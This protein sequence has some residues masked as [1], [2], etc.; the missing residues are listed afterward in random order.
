MSYLL[1]QLEV[2]LVKLLLSCFIEPIVE[3]IGTS[4]GLCAPEMGSYVYISGVVYRL[5]AFS[6]WKPSAPGSWARVA[7]P[8]PLGRRERFSPRLNTPGKGVFA[9]YPLSLNTDAAAA[10]SRLG[11]S[12]LRIVCR[13]TAQSRGPLLL[14]YVERLNNNIKQLLYM[15][16]LFKPLTLVDSKRIGICFIDTLLRQMVNVDYLTTTIKLFNN[17]LE[18]T[19]TNKSQVE[20]LAS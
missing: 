6:G 1:L 8:R 4:V 17:N 5:P 11:N 15:I 18:S 14:G 16:S 20:T 2:L 7:Q 13:S 3:G 9:F 10:G 12:R 19:F